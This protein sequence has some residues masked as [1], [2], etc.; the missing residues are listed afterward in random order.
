MALYDEQQLFSA[1]RDTFPLVVR[2]ETV[3]DKGRREGKTLQELRCAWAAAA[4]QGSGQRCSCVVVAAAARLRSTQDWP[5]IRSGQERRLGFLGRR[6][7]FCVPRQPA[8]SL[9]ANGALPGSTGGW[10][11]LHRG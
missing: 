2:L 10:D 11:W 5:W 3:T 7:G 6:C 9:R 8:A 4:K 1:G